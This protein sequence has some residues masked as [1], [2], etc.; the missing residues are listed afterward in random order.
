MAWYHAWLCADMHGCA[1]LTMN[2]DPTCID[3][4]PDDIQHSEHA[5]QTE[6]LS[7][8]MAVKNDS[9]GMLVNAQQRYG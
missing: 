7:Y 6:D 4:V 5:I 1:L 3:N 9:R 2:S 8:G